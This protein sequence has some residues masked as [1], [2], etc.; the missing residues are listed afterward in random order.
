MSECQ[1]V[2]LLRGLSATYRCWW[3]MGFFIHLLFVSV[4]NVYAG[5]QLNFN[6]QIERL[7]KAKK[8]SIILS[9]ASHGAGNDKYQARYWLD[10]LDGC[11]YYVTEPSEIAYLI[12]NLKQLNIKSVS[13]E[14]SFLPSVGIAIRFDF[15]NNKQ[16]QV[17]MGDIYPN[18]SVID[19]EVY[20]NAQSTPQ[21][22]MINRM[23]HRD[24]RRW[25]AKH[26]QISKAKSCGSNCKHLLYYCR[27]E[28]EKDFFRSN[29]NQTCG[30]PE[31]YRTMPDYCER[32]WEPSHNVKYWNNN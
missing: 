29:P 18:E 27:L 13:Q 11:Y 32:G 31:F 4:M 20:M 25:I 15:T 24:I 9:Q 23:I 10:R 5:E 12:A 22:F 19:G 17:L 16:M 30:I 3:L 26:G 14:K 21:T 8:V 6:Q 1:Q 7:K 28:V 2:K